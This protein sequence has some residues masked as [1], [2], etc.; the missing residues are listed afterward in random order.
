MS[1]AVWT[2]MDFPI[3]S[4]PYASVQ[5]PISETMNRELQ[6]RKI[7]PA[8]NWPLSLTEFRELGSGMIRTAAVFERPRPRRA[9]YVVLPSAPHMKRASK[10]VRFIRG[11]M[12]TSHGT[13]G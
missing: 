1:R 6:M 7:S 11:F 9:G 13:G 12:P 8:A 5:Y 4:K 2:R 3:T 10:Y